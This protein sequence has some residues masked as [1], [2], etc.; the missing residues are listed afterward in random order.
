[1]HTVVV[2]RTIDDRAGPSR[3]LPEGP[4]ATLTL[5]ELP[6]SPFQP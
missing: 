2:A 5:H 4:Q 3:H 1:M 6:A